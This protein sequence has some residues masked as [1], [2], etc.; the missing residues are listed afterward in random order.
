MSFAGRQK[1]NKLIVLYDS[2][3]IQL[4]TKVSVAFNE[5]IKKRAEAMQ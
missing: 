2:N 5:N 4:D 3:D 1:L